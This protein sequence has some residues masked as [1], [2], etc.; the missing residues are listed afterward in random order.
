MVERRKDG[1]MSEVRGEVLSDDQASIPGI[2]SAV[3][4]F[5]EGLSPKERSGTR[6]EVVQDPRSERRAV[7]GHDDS[8]KNPKRSMPRDQVFPLPSDMAKPK[9]VG[10]R[11]GGGERRTGTVGGILTKTEFITALRVMTDAL[12][13]PNQERRVSSLYHF[14][15]NLTFSTI[16]RTAELIAIEVERFPTPSVFSQFLG[17]VQRG[18]EN[19]YVPKEDCDVCN[20]YGWVVRVEFDEEYGKHNLAYRGACEHGAK[21]SNKIKVFQPDSESRGNQFR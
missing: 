3:E 11:D 19:N 16:K 18:N 5:L 14:F 8:L 1:D 6:V 7:R 21:L 9:E 15:G 10:G 2:G 12:P 13:A 20:G 17:R 4:G